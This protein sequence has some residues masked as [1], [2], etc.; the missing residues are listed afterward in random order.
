MDGFLLWHVHE[1]PNGEEDAKLIGVYSTD[2]LANQARQR[3]AT[4]PGFRD[5]PNGFIVD[6]YTLS[7]VFYS[8]GILGLMAITIC[9]MLTGSASRSARA[10]PEDANPSIS[11]PHRT[12]TPRVAH[13]DRRGRSF[14][15]QT[16]PSRA[17]MRR[18]KRS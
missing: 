17:A 13:S 5:H 2:E 1:L 10:T 12:G 6:R 4:L 14:E 16:H 15:T 11:S 9:Y 18:H 8:A 3:A 7:S